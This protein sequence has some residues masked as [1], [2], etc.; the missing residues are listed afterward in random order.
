M[1]IFLFPIIAQAFKSLISFYNKKRRIETYINR[2]LRMNGAVG[3]GVFEN[4]RWSHPD[5][6]A[7]M[8][9]NV[10]GRIVRLHTLTD[11]DDVA[12]YR[13]VKS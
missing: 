13:R 5:T 12:A 2:C 7:D 11:V 4:I 8:E 9:A 3:N 1:T 10:E 6:L